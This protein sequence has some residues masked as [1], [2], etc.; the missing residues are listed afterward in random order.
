ML[1]FSGASNF[2]GC[3]VLGEATLSPDPTIR[4]FGVSGHLTPPLRV[5]DSTPC[6]DVLLCEE[7]RLG[8]PVK[9][10]RQVGLCRSR[11]TRSAP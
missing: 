11:S 6:F 2:S 1:I 9:R 5:R 4:G 7:R 8:G 3:L 10:V